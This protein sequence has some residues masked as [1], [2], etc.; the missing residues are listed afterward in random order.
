MKKY[1]FYAFTA[2][3]L[4]AFAQEDKKTEVYQFQITKQNDALPVCSQ[5]KTGTCWSFATA[6]FLESEL[7]RM[8]KGKIDLSEMFIVKNI[9]KEKVEN[10]VRYHGKTNFGQG[11]LAHDYLNAVEKYGLMPNDAFYPEI[12][13][14]KKHNH[15][16]LFSVLKSMANT[17]ATSG[18]LTGKWK[19]GYQAVLDA[20]FGAD[21]ENFEYKGKTYNPESFKKNLKIEP[22]KY[23][24]ITSFTHLPMGEKPVVL[25][26]PDNWSRGSFENMPMT[27]MFEM[28]EMAILN[29]FT[30]VWDAD[31]SNKGF[32]SKKG[33]AIAPKEDNF[34]WNELKEPAKELEISQE[35]RQKEFDR[36][37]VT[38]DHL[39][40][41]TGMATDQKGNK[42]FVVKNSWGTKRGKEGF[43][44]YLFVSKAYFMLNTI[45]VTFHQDAT[46]MN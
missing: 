38:D 6:S 10:Y 12:H 11:S 31:V 17:F 14:D 15:K 13:I 32:N 5:G 20:Y 46:R 43:E 26:L 37:V 1:I 33:I 28:T 24:H 4:N 39:M 23:R 36:H 9:Y 16:E 30:V 44:G 40:H 27:M 7:M 34:S 8:G 42:Y 2:L 21:K 3:S 18:N 35:L 41:I 25:Q 29:G 45:A 19:V 22:K